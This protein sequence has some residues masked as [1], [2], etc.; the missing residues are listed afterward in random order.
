MNKTKQT[1]ASLVEIAENLGWHVSSYP[2]KGYTDYEFSKFSP[3]GQDFIIPV[4]NRKDDGETAT[5]AL[6][7]N[8]DEYIQNF[9]ATEE[10]LIWTGPDGHG[11]NGAPY[12]FLDIVKDMEDCIDMAKALLNAWKGIDKRMKTITVYRTIRLDVEYD[13]GIRTEEEATSRAIRQAVAHINAHSHTLDDRIRVI[14]AE[15]CGES[16]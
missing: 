4:D 1:L 9:D 8:L 16:N 15:D 2:Q 13:T 3:A 11:S 5:Q 6:I 10:A 12:E 14:S 7:R